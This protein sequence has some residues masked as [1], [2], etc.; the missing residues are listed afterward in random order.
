M[1]YSCIN[2][3]HSVFI[4]IIEN[5][6]KTVTFIF[7]LEYVCASMKMIENLIVISIENLILIVY[8]IMPPVL[9]LFKSSHFNDVNRRIFPARVFRF[10]WQNVGRLW[11]LIGLYLLALGR[12]G[13]FFL[14]TKF[15]VY[16]RQLVQTGIWYPLGMTRLQK[17]Q[18]RFPCQNT[19]VE[20][21]IYEASN[22]KSERVV[23]VIKIPLS[24]WLFSCVQIGR[25]WLVERG[26]G[27]RSHAPPSQPIREPLLHRQPCLANAGKFYPKNG[28][29]SEC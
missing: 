25:L 22:V 29:F 15:F 27:G 14:L 8:F 13:F 17:G 21:S 3:Q 23:F 2:D 16:K 4:T 9:L 12:I 19:F 11:T 28:I 18:K 20:M 10:W 6:V 26:G 7:V 5:V 1:Y 24:A